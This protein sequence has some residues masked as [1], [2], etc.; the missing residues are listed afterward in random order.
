MFTRQ[1]VLV[2]VFKIDALSIA[3]LRLHCGARGLLL[4]TLIIVSVGKDDLPYISHALLG[5]ARIGLA[6]LHQGSHGRPS[7]LR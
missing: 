3:I 7:G 2:N 6:H 4:T 1:D 5:I